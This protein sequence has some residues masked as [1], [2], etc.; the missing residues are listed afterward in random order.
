MKRVLLIA[1]FSI[2]MITTSMASI[3]PT[4]SLMIIKTAEVEVSLVDIVQKDLFQVAQYSPESN[5]LDFVTA[6]EIRYIQIFSEKGELK[7]QLPVLSRK[8]RISKGLFNSGEYR[9]GFIMDGHKTIEFT[10]VKVK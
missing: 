3:I 2:A 4:E 7:F 5:S 8:V 6:D 1:A 10:G 9:L